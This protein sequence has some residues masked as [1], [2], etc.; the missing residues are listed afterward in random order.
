ML[1]LVLTLFTNNIVIYF[2]ESIVTFLLQVIYFTKHL[3]REL[4]NI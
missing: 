3:K 1:W 2:S 4:K